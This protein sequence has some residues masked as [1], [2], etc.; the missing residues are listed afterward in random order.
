M[1]AR[2]P[3]QRRRYQA[4]PVSRR[5]QRGIAVVTALLVVALAASLAVSIVWRELVALRD[6]ENQRLAV[7]TLWLERAAVQWARATLR[8]QS[9]HANVTYVGQVWS[10]PVQ[11]LRLADILPGSTLQLNADLNAASLSGEV[12]DAQAKLNLTDLISR[13]GPRQPWQVDASGMRAY[14]QLLSEL[15]LTP[16]LADNA[17]AY[18][19]RSMNDTPGEGNWP[20]QLISIADLGK[21]PG[22]DAHTV[23]ALAPYVTLLPDYSYVNAN[24]ASDTVLAA[25]IPA[26]SPEQA[27]RLIEHRQTAFFVSTGDILLALTPQAGNAALPDGSLVSVNSGY[28]IVH[29]RIHSARLNI[30]MDTLIGRFGLGDFTT[31]R[32][33]WVHR[34][35]AG[36]A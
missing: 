6:I 1:D 2:A 28:F 23:G 27:H 16:A 20:M 15:S 8:E 17:A 14:R 36:E 33:L 5:H 24:T 29:C 26:L 21:V 4:H 10:T 18:M 32:V 35:S 7:E 31:T 12:E 13:P 30:R 25:A 11:N 22:Y 9:T 19:L 34:P 3:R